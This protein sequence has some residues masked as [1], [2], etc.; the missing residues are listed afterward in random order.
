MFTFQHAVMLSANR[1]WNSLWSP[2]GWI[3]GG[4]VGGW[5]AW[6]DEVNVNLCSLQTKVLT[7][8]HFYPLSC[9]FYSLDECINVFPLRT[10][11]HLASCYFLTP[12]SLIIKYHSES[13][14]HVIDSITFYFESNMSF[15]SIYNTFTC[16]S[17]YRDNV[18]LPIEVG[19]FP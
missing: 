11:E 15:F 4:G 5:F 8:G 19:W 13:L 14:M 3:I 12:G 2:V 17:L 1:F 18:R 7:L 10:Y 6:G 16:P 9:P